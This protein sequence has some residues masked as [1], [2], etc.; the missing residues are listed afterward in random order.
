MSVFIIN[1][2]QH[3]KLSEDIDHFIMKVKI[4]KQTSVVCPEKHIQEMLQTCPRFITYFNLH[5]QIQLHF[6]PN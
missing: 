2:L 1:V 4:K 5:L 3:K 6:P